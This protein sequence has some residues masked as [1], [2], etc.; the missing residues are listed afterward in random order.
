MGEAR[1][2]LE[3]GLPARTNKIKNSKNDL[4][5]LSSWWPITQ[6]QKNQF[7]NL[8]IRGGWFGIGLLVIIWITVRFVGPTL[9]WWVPA[10]LH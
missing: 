1:R 6:D 10:D 8:T 9:G 5:K 7:I 3:K 4:T 2:R